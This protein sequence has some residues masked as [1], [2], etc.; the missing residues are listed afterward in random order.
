M[1]RNRRR[2]SSAS[3]DHIE[4]SCRQR[5]ACPACPSGRNPLI[6]RAHVSAGDRETLGRRGPDG[7]PDGMG[8][9]SLVVDRRHWPRM[10]GIVNSLRTIGRKR[11]RRRGEASAF[12]VNR[13]A[14][15]VCNRPGNRANQTALKLRLPRKRRHS[16]AS[17]HIPRSEIPAS[18]SGSKP[19][20]L[21]TPATEQG[22][23]FRPGQP[24]GVAD[25]IARSHRLD[26]RC[27]ADGDP[28]LSSLRVV[29]ALSSPKRAAKPSAPGLPAGPVSLPRARP[30]RPGSRGPCCT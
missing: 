1:G 3:R 24:V 5:Q 13:G 10:G 15:R 26:R 20:S 6:T 23:P 30:H 28:R 19:H 21:R 27:P 4:G 12:S 7:R 22:E 11:K 18:G 9:L 17:G 25:A 14:G 2:K 29:Q 8:R 16:F